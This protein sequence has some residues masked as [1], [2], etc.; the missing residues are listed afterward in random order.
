[1]PSDILLKKVGVYSWQL[2][3]LDSCKITAVIDSFLVEVRID[4]E[5]TF[6]RT[7]I[8]FCFE[9]LPAEIKIDQDGMSTLAIEKSEKIT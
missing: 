4:M 1:M 7:F 5:G 6:R 8:Y 2:P 9:D 3:H